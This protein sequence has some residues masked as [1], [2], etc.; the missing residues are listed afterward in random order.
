MIKLLDVEDLDFEG[1]ESDRESV[2][3]KKMGI[4]D[5]LHWLYN[6]KAGTTESKST[7]KAI[8]HRLC[9]KCH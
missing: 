1:F 6:P 7:T 5:A 8:A 2:K 3:S 4:K 9:T